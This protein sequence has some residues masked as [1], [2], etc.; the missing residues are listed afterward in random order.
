MCVCAAIGNIRFQLRTLIVLVTVVA[1]LLAYWTHPVVVEE[2][3]FGGR[4]RTEI[5]IR[6]GFD[7][8]RYYDGPVTAYY[9]N[10][11]KAAQVSL[12]DVVYDDN[13]VSPLL[14][15]DCQFWRG[16]CLYP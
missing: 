1:I 16:W 9:A 4:L 13:A 10:G 11:Q 6:R 15:P 2:V 12:H 7:G 5:V 8:N 14:H 3:W